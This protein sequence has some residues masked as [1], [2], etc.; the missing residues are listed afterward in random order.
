MTGKLHTKIKTAGAVGK[1]DFFFFLHRKLSVL[2]SCYFLN[3]KIRILKL[4]TD[5]HPLLTDLP[6]RI[7]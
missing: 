4:N 3:L 5:V 7:T 2:L 6:I 1:G